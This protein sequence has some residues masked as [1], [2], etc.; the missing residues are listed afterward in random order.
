MT[1]KRAIRRLSYAALVSIAVF[2]LAAAE[3][4]GQVKFGGQPVPGATVTATQGDKKLVAITDSQGVYSFP[5]IAEGVWTMTVEML[6]FETG[7]RD[8]GVS[9]DAPS[10]VWDLK[11]LPT[12]Q[13]KAAAVAAPLPAPAAPA[14]SSAATNGTVT[15]DNQRSSV[16]PE[17]TPSLAAAAAAVANPKSKSNG[18]K[19]AAAPADS[20]GGFQRT[21]VNA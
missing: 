12:D 15:N 11:L 21:D 7:K 3:H 14:A 20:Q 2:G 17:T 13:L 18:K 16:P 8:I 4:H 9:P 1:W 10:P 6:C 5:D 19:P